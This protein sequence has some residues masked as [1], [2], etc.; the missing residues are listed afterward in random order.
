MF[1]DIE[2]IRYDGGDPG[3]AFGGGI[4]AASCNI[5]FSNEPTKIT[6]SV[7]AEKSSDYT[8][9]N[10][11]LNVT[12]TGAHTIQVGDVKFNRMYLYA[13]NFNNSPTSKTLTVQFID[14]SIC[15]DKIFVGL[16]TRHGTT[17]N[18]NLLNPQST[19]YNFSNT[20]QV[21]AISEKFAFRIMCLECNSLRP[22]KLM[23]PPFNQPPHYVKRQVYISGDGSLGPV[24]LGTYANVTPGQASVN[25]GYI[26][27]G[28]E[29]F[30]ETNCE[31]PK[32]E[33]T[34]DDL[35]NVLDYILGGD[36]QGWNG[37]QIFRHNLR[38]FKR[39]S[40]YSASYTGTLREVLS[41]WASDF[42]FDFV[43]DWSTNDLWIEA[44]D[45]AKSVELETIKDA[46]ESGF[47]PDSKGVNNDKKGAL[48]RSHTESF[49]LENTYKQ[50]PLVKYIKPPRPFDR[51]QKHYEKATGKVITPRDA[52]G[53]TANLGRTDNEL[54]IS[55]GLAK[56]SQEARIIWL[57]D[58]ARSKWEDTTWVNPL[59]NNDPYYDATVH[60][61][62]NDIRLRRD[63]PWMALGFFPAIYI[64]DIHQKARIA[65][66]YLKQ[67]RDANHKHPIWDNP[68]NYSVYF[69]I[70]N[71][72][73]QDKVGDFDKE[74]ADDFLGKYGY[75]WG[76][77]STE[78][79]AA[80]G[81]FNFGPINPPPD[82]RQ[83][84]NF[85]YSYEGR[86]THS[87]YLY[88]HEVTTLPD[89]KIY[90]GHSYPFDNILRANG[91]FFSLPPGVTDSDPCTY[92]PERSIFSIPD[93]AWGT[94]PEEVEKMLRNKYIIDNSDASPFL[95]QAGVL[96]DLNLYVPIYS[97]IDAN[98]INMLRN[99]FVE[100]V[101]IENFVDTILK[102][103]DMQAGYYPGIAI[104]PHL[105]KM[106]I[107]VPRNDGTT[108]SCWAC[109]SSLDSN[110]N[111]V[112]DGLGEI[113]GSEFIHTVSTADPTGVLGAQQNCDNL[114]GD[115]VTRAVP[116]GT[117]S[118]VLEIDYS[119]WE[120]CCDD[121][122]GNGNVT[123]SW[124]SGGAWAS[125]DHIAYDNRCYVFNDWSYNGVHASQI[126]SSGSY[127]TGGGICYMCLDAAGATLGCVNTSS[128]TIEN[129]L[130]DCQ[131]SGYFD[132]VSAM[133]HT[134]PPATDCCSG[135]EAVTNYNSQDPEVAVHQETGKAF[136]KTCTTD[137]F[138][139]MVYQNAQRRKKE[140]IKGNPNECVLV[141]EEDIVDTVCRC[142]D[143]EEPIHQFYDYNSRM[144][145]IKHLG[146]KV[147]I[148]F[149]VE[150]NYRGF[151]VSDQH[152]KGYYPEKRIVMGEPPLPEELKAANGGRGVME[153]RVVDMDVT[154][155]LESLEVDVRGKYEEQ[156]V[157]ENP[158]NLDSNGNPIKEVV[159]LPQY[160]LFMQNITQS[161]D[162]TN[163][164]IDVR[165]DGTE[166]DTLTQYM[167]PANGLSSFNVSIDSEGITTD[168]TFVSRPKRLPKRDVLMQK[169]GPRAIEGRIP[170]PQVNINR[171]DWG[172]RE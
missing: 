20:V 44:I 30:T 105:D 147:P 126:Y 116:C 114:Y 131:N 49:S 121:N 13:Y 32:V 54:Y 84:P 118:S 7:V 3:K 43:F 78:Q 58:L 6:L 50:T 115:D 61:S 172:V 165:V 89:S 154:Q 67:I 48:I 41:A 8:I 109:R 47:G 72:H 123:K 162:S 150:S 14:Q 107:N 35:C 91:G 71:E 62:V 113:K 31:I 73:Y 134:N 138:N 82:E 128:K 141:C 102:K 63:M 104:I 169:I 139:A 148:V 59:G 96:S 36:P 103:E 99:Y 64:S 167:T 15:L 95:Q 92:C 53:E 68:D 144:F 85:Y 108:G 143:I 39:S 153:T 52:I 22:S 55:M 76:N 124:T 146:Q 112:G 149:P 65:E 122:D 26:L 130:M 135:N 9:S 88:E 12:D 132:T 70:W 100:I 168:L 66:V 120:T 101:G 16:A 33:Y 137:I 24:P 23:T 90:K 119:H 38:D 1:K 27:L 40:T 161:A 106:K 37:T 4:Y 34:F 127:S 74:L 98:D 81:I 129:I 79:Q 75:W 80:A 25:G 21:T 18:L 56:Y 46:V 2:G 87:L 29:Q 17:H 51:K 10:D 164:R 93:N 5:G 142:D 110:G 163:E 160:F 159:S 19:T 155:D 117:T 60:S 157:V 151:W 77:R 133:A 42:S 145:W 170:K 125:T 152:E 69:G 158:Y 45:L 11:D 136:F 28:K 156:I 86:Q 83:C 140:S 94:P 171:N 166:F 111:Y 97:R 57:S